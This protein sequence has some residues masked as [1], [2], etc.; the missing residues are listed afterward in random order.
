MHAWLHACS[1]P[2][3]DRVFLGMGGSEYRGDGQQVFSRTLVGYVDS[4]AGHLQAQV[5][6]T[7]GANRLK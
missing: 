3:P 7:F 6:T 1:G 4:L 2:W 5:R